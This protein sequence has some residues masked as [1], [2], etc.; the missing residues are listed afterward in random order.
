VLRARLE[1]LE[2][3]GPEATGERE[4]AITAHEKAGLRR[5]ESRT[6]GL[7]HEASRRQPVR[8]MQPTEAGP[9]ETFIAAFRVGYADE[10]T[11][12]Q[13]AKVFYTPE[14][15]AALR[16]LWPALGQ[17]KAGKAEAEQSVK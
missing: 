7:K 10:G 3:S 1:M 14:M 15:I 5:V 13:M 17:K 6:G 12:R 9:P 11:A 16:W 4:R 8:P 2:W